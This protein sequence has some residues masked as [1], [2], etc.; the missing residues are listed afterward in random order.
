MTQI[1]LLPLSLPLPNMLAKNKSLLAWGVVVALFAA[2]RARRRELGERAWSKNEEEGVRSLTTKGREE[3]THPQKDGD[4]L[5]DDRRLFSP[6]FR[7]RWEEGRRPV[8]LWGK[9]GRRR[10]P[11]L[12]GERDYRVCE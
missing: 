5:L 6:H 10:D 7:K 8:G 1:P 4:S 3:T 2:K 11:L 9:G 12:S